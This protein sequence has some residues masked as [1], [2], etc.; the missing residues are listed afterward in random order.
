MQKH[1]S[2]LGPREGSHLSR[3]NKKRRRNQR[4]DFK[5]EIAIMFSILQG[6]ALP[7]A[8]QCT[9]K[10]CT[11]PQNLIFKYVWSPSASTRGVAQY[12]VS[13][14]GKHRLWCPGRVK[15]EQGNWGLPA[16]HSL[17]Q[18]SCFSFRNMP[19]RGIIFLPQLHPGVLFASRERQKCG[20]SSFE[21]LLRTLLFGRTVS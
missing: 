18:L 2:G 1:F 8:L 10:I 12:Q 17:C 3:T 15:R 11:R 4:S 7:V 13:A 21:E 16:V 5:W 14:F 6:K 20:A 9:A 19:F